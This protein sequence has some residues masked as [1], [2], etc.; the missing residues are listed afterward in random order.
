MMQTG[1][2]ESCLRTNSTQ[3]QVRGPFRHEGLEAIDI[4]SDVAKTIPDRD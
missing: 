1:N 3:E 2:R 4:D